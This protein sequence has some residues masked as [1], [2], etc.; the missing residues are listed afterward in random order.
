M[1]AMALPLL[2]EKKRKKK[3]GVGCNIYVHWKQMNLYQMNLKIRESG[4]LEY[5]RILI[6]IIYGSL[7][8]LSIERMDYLYNHK[9]K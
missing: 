6:W 7:Y 5:L 2:F 1:E 8:G 4:H 3:G 9:I